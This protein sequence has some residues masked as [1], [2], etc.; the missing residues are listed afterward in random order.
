[1][2]I[3]RTA[4]TD[5]DG[6]GTTGTPL[7]NAEKTLLYNQ[8][9]ASCAFVNSANVFTTNQE[10]SAGYPALILRDQ[11]AA[12]DARV[13]RFY[14]GTQKLFIDAL[15]DAMTVSLGTMLVLSRTGDVTVGRDIFERRAYDT[16]RTLDDRRREF[17]LP[18]G[19]IQRRFV[20]VVTSRK[21]VAASGVYER[22]ASS[23][24][25]RWIQVYHP[26][27]RTIYR[28]LATCHCLCLQE[29]GVHMRR[30]RLVLRLLPIST[31][32]TRIRAQSLRVPSHISLSFVIPIQ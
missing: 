24:N 27:S 18:S 29:P 15:N 20:Y 7:N 2:P 31:S 30:P 8:I 16:T 32:I 17:I 14:N 3:T 13:M 22:Y 19:W 26:A 21:D 12:A 5:D 6:T 28:V 4:W 1:M 25:W 10:I 23:S 9:D 11:G